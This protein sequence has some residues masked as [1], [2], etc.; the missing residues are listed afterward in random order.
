MLISTRGVVLYHCDYSE[1]SIIVK[2]YTEQFGLQSYI[3]KGVR[4]KGARIKRN[5][6]GPLSLVEL[7][8]YR[9]ENSGLQTIRDIFCFHQLND[10]AADISR[11]SVALFINELLYRSIS[12]EMADKNLF[13]FISETAVHLDQTRDN[14]G[15]YPLL[16]TIQLA[17]YLGIEPQNNFSSECNVFDLQEGIFSHQVPPHANYLQLPLS[18]ILSEIL[19]VKPGSSINVDA[20]TR[21]VL[22]EKLLEYFRLHIPSFGSMKSQA[23]LNIVLRD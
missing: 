16:F 2:I 18:G 4:K 20:Q 9:K 8:A 21:S 23:V 5:L 11:S 14:L 19:E 22:L 15:S 1:T 10:I 7:Q 6:F 13:G 3:A 12:G 17:H